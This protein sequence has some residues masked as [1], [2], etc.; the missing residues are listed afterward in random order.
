MKTETRITRKEYMEDSK[1]L[2]HSYYAQFV[3]E[4]TKLFVKE[5][6]GLD[7][8]MASSDKNLN[9]VCA[10]FPNY[11]GGNEPMWMWDIAPYNK[12]LLR[13]LGEFDSH[14]TATCV[15]KAAARML[16]EEYKESEGAR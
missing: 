4:A 13:D 11:R 5:R 15:S 2:H 7:K 14:S 8:I 12:G 9:D 6:I 10:Y 1:N 3:T 16:I